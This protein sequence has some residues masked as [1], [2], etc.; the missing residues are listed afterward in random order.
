MDLLRIPLTSITEDSVRVNAQVAVAAV[1]PE[2]VEPLPIEEVTLQGQILDMNGTYLFRGRLSGVF[3]HPCDRCLGEAF[4]PFDVEVCWNFEP[5]SGMEE[6][7]GD[8]DGL[9]EEMEIE[10]DSDWFVFQ[11]EEIDLRPCVWEELT[12]QAPIKYVCREDCAGLCPQCGTNRNESACACRQDDAEQWRA[13]TGL[14]GL[15][16]LFPE[17]ARKKPKE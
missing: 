12:L 4:A 17:L 2:D 9:A 6:R 8:G 7:E 10:D 1:Q 5:G 3:E 15:A 11:G 13:N 14:A 16:E